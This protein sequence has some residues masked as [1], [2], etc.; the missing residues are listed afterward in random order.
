MRIILAT[1]FL[2]LIFCSSEQNP[3]AMQEKLAGHW[4][5]TYKFVVSDDF[6]DSTYAS[7]L[8]FADNKFSV[9]AYRDTMQMIEEWTYTGTFYAEKDT[10]RLYP[11]NW[12]EIYYMKFN[13]EGNLELSASYSLDK[14][15]V[16]LGDFTS[17]LWCTYPRKNGIFI[18]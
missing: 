6:P 3:L 16:I 12:S 5:E 9:T 17:I 7:A 4:R 13:S 14:N 10:L 15:G 2:F 18:R 1:V 11:G 8:T